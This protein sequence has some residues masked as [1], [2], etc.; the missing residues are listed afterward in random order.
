MHIIGEESNDVVCPLCG[1]AYQVDDKESLKR[2]R[3]VLKDR[4]EEYIKENYEEAKDRVNKIL[5]M[6]ETE[7]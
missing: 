7:G 3:K 6:R 5:S 4:E 1:V 2:L